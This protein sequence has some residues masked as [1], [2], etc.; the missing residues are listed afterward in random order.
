MISQIL[1]RHEIVQELLKE[2]KLTLIYS[3]VEVLFLLRTDH[4]KIQC[5]VSMQGIGT[6]YFSASI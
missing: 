5:L 1:Y 6:P 4:L 3:L 2:N